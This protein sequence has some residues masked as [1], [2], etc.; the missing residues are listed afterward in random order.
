MAELCRLSPNACAGK[1]ALAPP[2]KP[3]AY[4]LRFP[5]PNFFCDC[6]GCFLVVVALQAAEVLE[7]RL[8]S[9]KYSN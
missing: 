6:K 2:E 7:L 5:P 4:F 1:P 3:F 9:C 8:T